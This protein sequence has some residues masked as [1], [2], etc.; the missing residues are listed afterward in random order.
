MLSKMLKKRCDLCHL[1]SLVEKC[2]NFWIKMHIFVK[3]IFKMMSFVKRKKIFSFVDS[4]F[5]IRTD[6]IK[7]L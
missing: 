2:S 4:I 3:Y 1:G 6:G 7:D 5:N